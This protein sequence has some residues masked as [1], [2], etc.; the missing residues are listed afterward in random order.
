MCLDT[1]VTTSGEDK[2]LDF[3]V[4]HSYLRNMLRPLILALTVILGKTQD[5]ISYD[6]HYLVNLK[7]ANERDIDEFNRVLA[8]E[9]AHCQSLQVDLSEGSHDFLC[10]HHEERNGLVHELHQSQIPFEVESQ[11]MRELLLSEKQPES[12]NAI[13]ISSKFNYNKYP[14]FQEIVNHLNTIEK[15][16]PGVV[17]NE[18]VGAT[19]ENRSLILTTIGNSPMGQ[20]TR[21]VW[22]D[23]G[24]HAREWISPITALFLIDRI[25]EEFRKEPYQQDQRIVGV[26]WYFM[27][28][29]NPD[30]YEY[31]HETD[32]MWRKNR[33]PPPKGESCYGVDLN[34]N[35]DVIGFGIGASN[36]ACKDNF[37]GTKANSEPEVRAASKKLLSVKKN[38]RVALS[39]H[40]AGQYWLTSWGYKT[41]LPVDNDKM[42]SLGKKAADAIFR[43][44]GRRYKVGSAG[45][46]LYPAGGASDDFAKARALIPYAATIE[47]PG[48]HGKRRF[49]LPASQIRSV[50]EEMFAAMGVVAEVAR[51]HPLGDDPSL[52]EEAKRNNG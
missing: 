50:G 2:L 29:S 16:N 45:A 14:R 33:A 12:R 5:R 49:V 47:L 41:Q 36:D 19:H 30:G 20:D 46:L 51:N 43:T 15:E 3:T 40:S 25:A 32:R 42:V 48:S 27:P 9:Q 13:P 26:D 21:A 1:T 35:W 6:N 11:S 24:I 44:S 10:Q 8:K 23:A 38:V 37:K 34:R 31:S 39:L 22:I 17:R 52:M 7:V 18:R 4:K 28:I